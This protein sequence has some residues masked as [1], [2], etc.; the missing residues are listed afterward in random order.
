[1]ERPKFYS[2]YSSLGQVADKYSAAGRSPNT[3]KWVNIFAL[4]VSLS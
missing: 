4:P 1:M 2:Y 3:W